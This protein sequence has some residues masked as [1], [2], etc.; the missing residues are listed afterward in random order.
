MAKKHRFMVGDKVKLNRFT[1]WGNSW[2]NGKIT[3]I[4]FSAEDGKPM[5]DVEIASQYIKDKKEITIVYDDARKLLSPEELEK[6]IST[7]QATIR[8]RQLNKQDARLERQQ[9]YRDQLFNEMWEYIDPLIGNNRE[10]AVERTKVLVRATL[11]KVYSPIW[12]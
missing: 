2:V 11:N 3:R 5:Y 10:E 8:S 1:G 12:E 7:R 4:F 6:K 9:A